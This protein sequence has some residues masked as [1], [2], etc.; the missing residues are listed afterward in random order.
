[1]KEL[2][3]ILS[4]IK[5]TIVSAIC[6]LISLCLMFYDINPVLNPAWI[7]VVISGLPIVFKAFNRLVFCCCISSPLLITIAMI[8]AIAIG[9]L[10]A[11]GEVA[12]IMAI[13]ELLEDSTVDKAKRG[14]GRLLELTPTMGRKIFSDDKEEMTSLSNIREGDTLRILAGE[15]IPVDG[16]IIH[17]ETSVNQ[18]TLTGESLPID[19]AIGDQVMAGTVN[20]FGVIDIKVLSVKDTYLQKMI[21]LVKEAENKKAPTQKIVD[22]WAAILVPSALC[23]AIL[24][25]IFTG[26]LIRAV[27]VLVVFCPC[28]LV[29]ATPTS[30]MAAIGQA[31]KRGVIIKSGAALEEM[32]NVDTIVFDKTGTLTSGKIAVSD[33]ISVAK[34]VKKDKLLE[35]A[36]S[37]EKCSEHALGKAIVEKA[38]QNNITLSAVKNFQIK[39]GKGVK[40]EIEHKQILA[41]NIKFIQENNVIIS[42]RALEIINKLSL[43]GKALVIIAYEKQVIGIIGLKDE[44]RAETKEAISQL[45]K[46]N[47]VPYILTGDNKIAASLFAKISGVKKVYADLLPYDKVKHIENLQRKKYCVCMVGDGINDAPALKCAN[48]SLAMGTIG[49]DIAVDAADIALINDNILSIPYLKKLSILTVKTIQT[50]ISIS[51]LL[52]IVGII[53]SINGV[54]TP[55]T[56]AIM[57]NLG[58]VLVVL[59][60]AKLYDRKL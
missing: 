26:E 52:N 19:K 29:L 40:G 3:E 25:Y 34:D 31:A 39:A 32:G 2:I 51:M 38:K 60:A 55:V 24:T 11:A 35:I 14:L 45:S 41:G 27:T 13:G 56:G 17:G 36:A 4:G 7:T 59:N 54:L 15:T 5:L 12:L 22:K 20:Q 50:N 28:A 47:I 46:Q 30:I 8:S 33:I 42:K 44:I 48:V 9:E 49:S 23:L 43:Q 10:F 37:I 21:N 58:S 53:L 6:L 18:A 57:H 1:M 16:V